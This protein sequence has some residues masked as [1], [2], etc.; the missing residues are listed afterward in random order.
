MQHG[1]A[2]WKNTIYWKKGATHIQRGVI[3]IIISIL[4][5]PLKKE[6]MA[7]IFNET[8][9]EVGVRSP[10]G[11][12]VVLWLGCMWPWAGQVTSRPHSPCVRSRMVGLC[13]FRELLRLKLEDSH[14]FPTHIPWA[15]SLIHQL[16]RP[17]TT[18][19]L[20]NTVYP[21]KSAW[22]P[23]F[24]DVRN[25]HQSHSRN[26][27][28]HVALASPTSGDAHLFRM[29]GWNMRSCSKVPRLPSKEGSSWNGYPVSEVSPVQK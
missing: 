5:Y 9:G 8:Q 25:R 17:A 28:L 21:T 26:R 4:N 11:N 29:C 13:G 20:T 6:D 2:S 23:P 12:T 3:F 24:S 1:W 16:L 18:A 10:K 7:R 14:R 22:S 15:S 27:I 19:V